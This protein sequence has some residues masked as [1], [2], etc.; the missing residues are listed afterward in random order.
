MIK[1][2]FGKIF[3]DRDYISQKLF[4]QLLEQGVFIV[5][6]VKKNMKNKLMSMLD[7]ILLLKR[8]LIE[9][10]FSKIKLLS[11]F[12]H[13]RHRSVTNAFVHMIAALIN[14]QMSDNKPSITSLLL[15]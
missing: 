1:N 14:Y 12:E 7:K 6:R 3:G 15:A 11:K 9:S 10:V 8:S 4:Q 5:T 2:L 13:S